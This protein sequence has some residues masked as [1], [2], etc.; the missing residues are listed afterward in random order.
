[1]VAN[2]FEK[3]TTSSGFTFFFPKEKPPPF[4]LSLAAFFFLTFIKLVIITFCSLS[5]NDASS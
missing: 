1:M 5:L 4:F 2:C 3:I